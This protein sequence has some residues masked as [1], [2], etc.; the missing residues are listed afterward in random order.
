MKRADRPG[1][2]PEAR[3]YT[4]LILSIGAVL[5]FALLPG[6]PGAVRVFRLTEISLV[7]RALWLYTLLRA[8]AEI[9]LWLYRVLRDGPPWAQLGRR[10]F[11]PREAGFPAPV[12]AWFQ[13]LYRR[14][15]GKKDGLR[16]R[17]KLLD[18]ATLCIASGFVLYGLS[19]CSACDAKYMY[20]LDCQSAVALSLFGLIVVCFAIDLK[21]KLSYE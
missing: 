15:I 16:A 17:L 1:Q 19:R 13:N 7:T 11:L 20:S 18:L 3:K 10:A 8:G 21:A 2:T 5:S 9:V 12:T 4:L 14:A 6:L